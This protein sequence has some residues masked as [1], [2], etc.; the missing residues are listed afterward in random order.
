MKKEQGITLIALIVY[1]ILMTFVVAGVTAITNSFYNNINELDKTSESAVSFAKFN[2]YFI[3]D[4]K[5]EN[6]QIVSSSSNQVQISFTNRNGEN[7]TVKYSIQNK[8]LYRDKIKICDKVN[9][10]NITVNNSTNT[11]TVKLLINNY[12]KTTVYALEPEIL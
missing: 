6:V 4:I 12:E 11:I 5:S 9:D 10:S 2:M 1:I 3:N 8:T 7:Q